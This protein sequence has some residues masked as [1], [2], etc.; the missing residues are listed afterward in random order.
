MDT[1]I[2]RTAFITGGARGIGLGIARACARAGTTLALVDIDEDALA[3]AKTELSEL[4]R[5][6]TYV[7]DVRDR[8]AY[9]RVADQVE[10][11]LG[12]VSLLF[13]N[14]GVT[15][16]IS[17]AQMDY[18]VWDWVMGV[19]IGGI[20]NGMQTFVPRMI[21]RGGDSYI[22]NS[23]SAAGLVFANTG[24]P[25]QAS[26]FAVVGLTE[27]LH[28]EL[29]GY[30]IGIS[31]LLPGPVATDI[32]RNAQ[33]LRPEHAPAQSQKVADKLENAHGILNHIGVSIDEVGQLTLDAIREERFY[34]PTDDSVATALTAR[35]EAL[36]AAMSSAR[37][38]PEFAGWAQSPHR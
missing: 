35:T 6:E 34:I 22:V 13:N 26:K 8:E 24:F 3:Q 23:A 16:I 36:L 32:V 25:Y 10:S 2:G 37:H 38:V 27:T 28:A 19:N 30:G 5:T 9:A 21:S 20:Y 7:L 31:L 1:F 33:R 29:A 12:V 18:A 14:A 15:D 4:T 11:D 17:P